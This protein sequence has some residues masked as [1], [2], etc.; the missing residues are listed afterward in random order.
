M[1]YKGDDTSAP[2]PSDL[3]RSH[4]GSPA[5]LVSAFPL[6]STPGTDEI[7]YRCELHRIEY[8]LHVSSE[9]KGGDR[10]REYRI[11]AIGAGGQ[12]SGVR[13]FA[14][15]D[16]AEAIHKAQQAAESHHV[17]ELWKGGRLVKQFVANPEPR[18][19]GASLRAAPCPGNASERHDA[20]FRTS[21]PSKTGGPY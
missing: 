12:I 11:Y 20:R 14:C 5:R 8:Q 10:A 6:L 3:T 17:V 9:K 15:A 16:D 1:D 7:T 13:I 21:R 2:V 18:I 4:R 19:S